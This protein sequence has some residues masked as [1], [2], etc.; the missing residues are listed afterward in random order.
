MT[1]LPMGV[2]L[3]DVTWCRSANESVSA[4]SAWLQS[5]DECVT[6]WTCAHPFRVVNNRLVN[7]RLIT[8]A[9]C[10]LRRLNDTTTLSRSAPIYVKFSYANELDDGMSSQQVVAVMLISQTKLACKLGGRLAGKH[11]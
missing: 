11:P 6:V 7:N 1:S 10:L 2:R 9:D 3:R 5:A 8:A 4:S